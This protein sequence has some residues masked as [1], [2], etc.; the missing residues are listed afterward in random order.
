MKTLLLAA[1]LAAG[2][3]NARAQNPTVEYTAIQLSDSVYMLKGRGGNVAVSTGNEGLFIVDDQVRSVT[4]Q[5]LNA[6]HKLS[7]KPIRFVLNTHYHGDHVGGNEPIGKGGALIISQ[8]NVRERMAV[9]QDNNFSKRHTPPY[10]HVAL[11]LLTFSDRI[12]L[13]LNSEPVTVYHVANAHTDGDSIVYFPVSN[14]IHMG[15]TFF[16]GQYPYVDLDAG[17]S[18]QGIVA[19]VELALSLANEDTR[20]IPGHGPLAVTEEL[21]AYHDFL[22]K[23]VA[24]VQALVDDGNDLTQIIAAKPTAEWD[25]RYGK[26]WITPPQ[27]VAFVYYSLK[28]IHKYT[29]PV[30]PKTEASG[31]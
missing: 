9:A 17:G 16:N 5:L 7:D 3:T 26:T 14:V 2:V 18:I 12:T 28:G 4:G 24:N 29:P 1:V 20:V 31:S 30:M 21:R 11:P 25:D 10:A 22:V 27:F 19:A 23:A 15:D 6:I 13:H 8:D